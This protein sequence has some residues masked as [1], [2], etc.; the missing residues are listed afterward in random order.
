MGNG[1]QQA[2]GVAGVSPQRKLSHRSMIVLAVALAT[3]A[4]GRAGASWPM[5]A[6]FGA[7]VAVSLFVR[8]AGRGDD[9]FAVRHSATMGLGAAIV[10]GLLAWFA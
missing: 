1:P 5:L 2:D 9:R 4:V 6:L 8:L 10:A 7:C 3:Y